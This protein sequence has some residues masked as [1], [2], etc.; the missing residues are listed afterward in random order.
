MCFT[1]FQKENGFKQASAYGLLSK[2]HRP[3]HFMWVNRG[4]NRNRMTE[5]YG[6]R[7]GERENLRCR[8]VKETGVGSAAW[9][10][11]WLQA[12]GGLEPSTRSQPAL[13]NGDTCLLGA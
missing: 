11:M 9:V 12:R 7:G 8:L 1:G 2:P 13:V 3:L 5:G 4:I 10:S 6:I